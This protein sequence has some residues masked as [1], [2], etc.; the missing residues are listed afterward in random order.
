MGVHK[1]VNGAYR[2]RYA[3]FLMSTYYVMGR[4]PLALPLGE[5]S[6]QVTERD[7]QPFSNDKINLCAHI[8]EIPVVRGVSSPCEAAGHF[9]IG[10]CLLVWSLVALSVLAT[11]GHLSQGERQGMLARY[12]ERYRSAPFISSANWSLLHHSDLLLCLKL[13][14][15]F[16][17]CNS[18]PGRHYCRD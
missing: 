14:Y 11:L 6:P 17:I 2:Y 15:G 1:T 4:S 18:S 12:T 8:T 3:P 10:C 9:L 5:L 13:S 7:L 16:E